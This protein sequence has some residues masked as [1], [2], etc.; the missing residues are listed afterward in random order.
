MRKTNKNA[1]KSVILG[2]WLLKEEIDKLPEN[3]TLTVDH[4]NGNALDNRC[5]NLRLADKVLQAYNRRRNKENN[6]SQYRGVIKDKNRWQSYIRKAGRNY[7]C[8]SFVEEE[9][10][11][12]AYDFKAI[13]LYGDDAILNFPN[14]K[15]KNKEETNEAIDE[16]QT[17][18]TSKVLTVSKQK[19]GILKVRSA[20]YK[21]DELL[22]KHT[23]YVTNNH[24]KYEK[25]LQLVRA[26]SK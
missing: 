18:I 12:M 14:D 5:C 23:S 8:G 21:N 17:K 25:L 11:A 4:I 13:E 22:R 9:D 26:S 15:S 2:R 6:Q 20:I 1:D 10:A 3:S 7:Y 24:P 19:R 16:D